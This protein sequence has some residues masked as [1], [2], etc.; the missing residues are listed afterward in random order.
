MS[1]QLQNYIH[2]FNEWYE[3]NY[4]TSEL[5]VVLIFFGDR[6]NRYFKIRFSVSEANLSCIVYQLLR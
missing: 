1:G 6:Q 2:Y 5:L 4:I 3:R